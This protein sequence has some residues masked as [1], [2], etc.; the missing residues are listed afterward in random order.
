[1]WQTESVENS[2]LAIGD[3]CIG[4]KSSSP[5]LELV[6]WNSDSGSYCLESGRESGGF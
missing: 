1:M 4:F 6:L 3:F 5:S 2:L